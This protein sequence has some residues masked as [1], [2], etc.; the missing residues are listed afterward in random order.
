MDA[1]GQEEGLH[2]C[3]D[4]IKGCVSLTW[5]MLISISAI[6]LLEPGFAALAMNTLPGWGM[7]AFQ[8]FLLVFVSQ[9]TGLPTVRTFLMPFAVSTIATVCLMMF[10]T[11]VGA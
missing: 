4:L 1:T 10:T 5:L 7:M 2:G 9:R 11:Q 6:K 3:A 8:A